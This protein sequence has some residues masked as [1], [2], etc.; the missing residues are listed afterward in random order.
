MQGAEIERS[1]YL[2]DGFE[3]DQGVAD[4]HEDRRSVELLRRKFVDKMRPTRS[5]RKWR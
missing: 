2:S 5:I 1:V 3:S 4:G